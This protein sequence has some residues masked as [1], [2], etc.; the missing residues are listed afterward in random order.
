MRIESMVAQQAVLATA[1]ALGGRSAATAR[2][3]SSR[4]SPGSGT[5]SQAYAPEMG[6]PTAVADRIASLFANDPGL[7]EA[8]NAQL[9]AAR[10]AL[11]RDLAAYS[12]G[13]VRLARPR[14]L[15]AAG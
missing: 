10:Q 6:L 14:I 5:R 4:P 12:R 3:V 15:D 1:T 8:V 9:P 7:A 2:T 13:E 11:A